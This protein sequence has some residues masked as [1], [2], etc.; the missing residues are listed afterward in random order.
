MDEKHELFC[1]NMNFL[2]KFVNNWPNP[3]ENYC[4]LKKM[5]STSVMIRLISAS[6]CAANK[7]GAIIREILK[8]GELGIVQKVGPIPQDPSPNDLLLYVLSPPSPSIIIGSE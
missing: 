3:S 6:V 4:K 2:T 7:S 5:S 1:E 8:T